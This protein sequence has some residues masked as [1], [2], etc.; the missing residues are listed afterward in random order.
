MGTSSVSSRSAVL[1]RQRRWA[2]ITGRKADSRGYLATVEANLWQPM[3]EQSRAAFA[4]GSGSELKRKMRALHSS[5]ALAVN[6]FEF[7]TKPDRA[8]LGAALNLRSP[9]TE[10]AFEA[11]HH[12]GLEGNPPNLDVCL[13]L[14]SGHTVAI[15]SKF[16]EWL[17][18]KSPNK[19][20]FKP[21][22][23]PVGCELWTAR[24]L[25]KCQ[26]LAADIRAKR[27]HFTFLDAPQ[28]LKHALGLATQLA[29]RFDLHYIYCDWPG[30]ESVPHKAELRRFSDRVGT[31]L[32]F[33]AYTYQDLLQRLEAQQID[34]RYVKY[35][36]ERYLENAA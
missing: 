15:E 25:P 26:A 4:K 10:I 2:R 17:S 8:P 9:I 29:E 35:L 16:C 13:T 11:Q 21:K 7:W 22:Y 31:E 12:T 23:F 32:R 36:R 18:R 1:E 19:E 24:G 14:A 6:F 20:H 3:C 27:E 30:P 34:S 28:L 5:S 33:K